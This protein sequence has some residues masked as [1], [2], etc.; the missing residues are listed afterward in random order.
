MIGASGARMDDVADLDGALGTSSGGTIHVLQSLA[1]A[2]E[3]VV[4]VHEHAH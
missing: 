3:F 2:T 4:L 1:P